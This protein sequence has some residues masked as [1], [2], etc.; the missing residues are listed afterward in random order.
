MPGTLVRTAVTH[1]R[2]AI[3][4]SR[5]QDVDFVAAIGTIFVLPHLAGP[6]MH[7]QPERAAVSQRV[8]FR[9][10]A[11]LPHERIV[12]RDGAVV[13]QTQHLAAKRVGILRIAA[14]GGHVEHAVAAEGDARGA[15]FGQN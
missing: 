15:G 4:A 11:G 7:G 8:D 14:G 6:G 1:Q 9:P 12:G 5:L 10:M 3:V 13:A 2:P